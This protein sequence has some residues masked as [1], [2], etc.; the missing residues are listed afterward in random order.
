MNRVKIV[1]ILLLTIS[2]ITGCCAYEGPSFNSMEKWVSNNP[3]IYFVSLEHIE[4]N[5]VGLF[6][7]KLTVGNEHIDV[8]V[9][10]DYGN[11]I[12][13]Y[14]LGA[15]GGSEKL[16]G[17]SCEVD[18]DEIIVTIEDDYVNLFNGEVKTITFTKEIIE[19]KSDPYIAAW[20][21]ICEE[22]INEAYDEFFEQIESND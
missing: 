5:A 1:L 10:F 21:K 11:G 13:F 12:V 14:P 16:F 18:K 17:G 7:G 8:E 22:K 15:T 19:P 9:V 3:D 4:K 20:E 2:I 6:V